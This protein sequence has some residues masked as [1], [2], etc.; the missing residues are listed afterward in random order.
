MVINIINIWGTLTTDFGH[1]YRM[2]DSLIQSPPSGQTTTL[3][4]F[5]SKRQVFTLCTWSKKDQK[6]KESLIKQTSLVKQE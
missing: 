6:D 2:V 5:G 1:Y 4:R 3:G